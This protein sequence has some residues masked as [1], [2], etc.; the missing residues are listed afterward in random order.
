MNFVLALLLGV[1]YANDQYE[2]TASAGLYGV[3]EACESDKDCERNTHCNYEGVCESDTTACYDDDEG[4]GAD[5]CD[6]ENYICI[7]STPTPTEAPKP[8]C[9]HGDLTSYKANDKC[10]GLEDQMSCERKSCNWLITDDPEDCVVTTTTSPPRTTEVGCCDSDSARS[11]DMCDAKETRAK[12]ERSSSCFFVSGADAVCEPPSTS[13]TP[14]CCYGNPDSAYSNRWM[15]ACTGYHT[16]RECLFNEDDLGVSRCHWEELPDSYDCS[17]LWPTTTA[18]TSSP[19]TTTTPPGCCHG[20]LTSYKANEKCFG[21]DNQQSCE[22]K[23][24]NWLLTDD[25]EDCVVTTTTT[26]PTTTESG[27]CKGTNFKSNEGCNA[28][29]TERTCGR[30]C[31]WI[32]GGDLEDDCAM[33]TT[34]ST[35]TT[36]EVGCCKGDSLRSTDKCNALTT[37]KQ[38]DRMSSCN[39]VEDGVLEEDCAAPT[40][41]ASPGCCY[42]N[43]EAAYSSRWMEACKAFF[44]EKECLMLTDDGDMP[45]CF[46][47]ELGE[48][49]DCEQQWPTTTSTPAGCC[50]GDLTSYK[51]NEKCVGIDNQNSCE[52]KSCSWLLTEDPEECVITTTETPEGCCGSD[53]ASMFDMCNAKEDEKS[54]NRFSSCH[55]IV[56]DDDLCQKPITTIEPG[57]CYI[58]PDGEYSSRVQS[59]CT[60]FS[61]EEECLHADGACVWESTEEEEDCEQLW[62]TTTSTSTPTTTETPAGCC[63]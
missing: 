17:M 30:K 29:L 18:T 53:S 45:R 38:C 56:G 52:R 34:T 49:E 14:G 21:I 27:C 63:R 26:E 20:D 25:P 35:P 59:F 46:W 6:M 40:T 51:A 2:T 48:Y 22:R 57:C 9:C 44:T 11:F 43:P 1:A 16:E 4:R 7:P 8:G 15:A 50:H 41:L 42:G 28:M 19:T 60:R 47:E 33:T 3:G 37:S 32:P 5:V 13:T 12:C 10:V 55:W 61:S 31:V 39:W 23:S 58:N 54:C 24:C 36:T 62:P